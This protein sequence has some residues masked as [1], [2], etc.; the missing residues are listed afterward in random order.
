MKKTLRWVG[1]A[2]GAVA[3]LALVSIGWGTSLPI[4]HS[5]TCSA[6]YSVSRALVWQAVDDDIGSARWRS[7]IARIESAPDVDGHEYYTEFDRSGK[8]MILVETD[9]SPGSTIVRTIV[10]QPGAAFGGSWTYRVVDDR[11]GAKVTIVENG[12]VYNPI[13]RL[14]ARLTGYTSTMQQYLVDLGDHFGETT[15]A[16]CAG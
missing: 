15:T 14:A 7:N 5:A 9:G 4:D 6:T 16:D 2:L 10:E 13:F 8:S 12:E 11:S 1:A 3:F